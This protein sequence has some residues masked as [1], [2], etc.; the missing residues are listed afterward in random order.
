MPQEHGVWRL[1]ET[2]QTKAPQ[3]DAVYV[4]Q[5]SVGVLISL[6]Q[7]CLI[8]S[9]QAKAHDEVDVRRFCRRMQARTRDEVDV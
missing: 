3:G 1:M 7:T 4:M 6:G 9:M 8:V 5:Q 2:I